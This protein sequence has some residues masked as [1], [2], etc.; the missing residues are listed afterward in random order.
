MFTLWSMGSLSHI[1][2]GQLSIMIPVVCMGLLLSVACIKS[3]NLLLLGE[4]YA[5]TMG[6]S[7]KRS[8]TLVFISTALLTGTVTAFCGPV[9]FIG[10][11]VPHITRLLFDNADHRILMPGTMLTGLIAML[12]CDIIAKKF[13]LPVNCITRTAGVPVILWVIGKTCVYS[14][15]ST[16]RPD[17][18]IRTAYAA[19]KVSAHITGGTTRRTARQKRHRKK[20]TA[21]CRHGTGKSPKT[22]E[23]ILHGN[24]IASL[25]PEEL[26]R[27]ISFVTTDKVRIA[28][29]RCRDVVALG[30]AP[31]PT[32]SV[33]CKEK[34]RRGGQR[35][36]PGRHGQLCGKTMDK[37]SDGECQR[38]MIARALAQDT[39]VI[40]ARFEPTAFLWLAQ[41]YELC[42]F[43]RKLT[44]KE[45][46]CILFSTHDLDIAPSH[47]ATQSCW[48]IILNSTACLPM[49]W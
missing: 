17:T 23:I 44:Q 27:N 45:G 46:K 16:Q 47:F 40:P 4:N 5:R 41:R 37:M 10:L 31:I 7:I 1:T 30:R 9:G 32:G 8:R 36:A 33:S 26:A 38:I 42:L 22:G 34:T 15:D 49:R 6:M 13:L 29:L 2:A 11:A 14:N 24:N 21:A 25:K 12:I 20:Y 43:L 48:L 35:H 18:G 28:N 3:L 39:P 19:G